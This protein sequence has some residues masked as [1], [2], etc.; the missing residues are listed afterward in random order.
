MESSLRRERVVVEDKEI[1]LKR[2][3]MNGGD[4]NIINKQVTD[5]GR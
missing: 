5:R 2:R 4:C 1:G 3:M